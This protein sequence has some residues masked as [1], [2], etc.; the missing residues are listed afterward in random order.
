MLRPGNDTWLVET[1]L[2]AAPIGYA[3]LTAPDLPG[4]TPSNLELKRIYLLSICHGSGAGPELMRRVLARAQER[5]AARLL[6]S[7]YSKNPRAIAFYKKQG[8]DKI[9]DT[10]FLVG[11]TAYDDFVLA[12]S[13]T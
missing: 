3:M 7:V 10:R 9:G 2:T 12:R 1:A 5:G 4:C 6:L 8:F 11:E 13:L